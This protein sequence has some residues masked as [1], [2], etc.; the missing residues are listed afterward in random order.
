MDVHRAP[1]VILRAGR[2]EEIRGGV[3]ITLKA[4][5]EG[6]QPLDL[7]T[8]SCSFTFAEGAKSP[9]RVELNGPVKVVSPRATI[10]SD[11]AVMD[12][13]EQELQFIGGVTGNHPA[14]T[15]MRGSQLIYDLESGWTKVRNMRVD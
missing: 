12:M 10:S 7:T 8:Q 9:S 2:I 11:N 1:E 6:Q 13:V 5:D 4:D 14:I 3:E 15:N